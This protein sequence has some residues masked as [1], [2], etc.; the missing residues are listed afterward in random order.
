MNYL[1]TTIVLL[2]L[3][4]VILM[5]MRQH[6]VTHIK[7]LENSNIENDKKYQ[8]EI[9]SR[10]DQ[11]QKFQRKT[12]ALNNVVAR[13]VS[14]ML[15]IPS[16]VQRLNTTANFEEVT[17]TITQL[18][19][20]IIPTK[21]VDLYYLD[22]TDNLLKKVSSTN[23][24][25]N[26][27]VS[28]ALGEGLI[29]IAA[30]ERMVWRKE[31]FEKIFNHTKNIRQIDG[32]L[33]M[34]VPISFRERVL[35]VIGIGH[36]AFPVGNES[37]IMRMIANIAG[38]ALI[39]QA[40]LKEAKDKANTDSLTGLNNRYYLQHMAQNFIE[41]ALRENTPI[42]IFLFDIDNFKHYND[43]NGHDEGDKLLKELSDLVR[44]V[45]RKNS[46]IVRYGGEEFLVMLPAISKEDA[47]VYAERFRESVSSHP[48]P[49][50][51]EQPLG[52][53]SI[54]GGIASFPVDGE[55]IFK[56]IQLADKALYQAKSEGKNRVIKYAPVYFSGGD[57]EQ[58]ELQST[59][60]TL[61]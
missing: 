55:T 51:E 47:A 3:A 9:F 46:V 40:M 29:G 14:F 20:D 17:T 53:L 10:D 18:V 42:S 32:A 26:E 22:A 23:Q 27:D 25:D 12:D 44:S 60:L 7:D 54:S 31:Q 1:I 36:V 41:K 48:F 21:K 49:H 30:R 59:N 50:R 37:D 61:I 15:R 5:I 13:Y 11:I 2:S 19:S 57:A 39:N 38:V 58:D 34:A 33:W 56:V 43:T 52:C 6:Y 16:V 35:G 4:A 45:T 8:G 24:G 28:Y